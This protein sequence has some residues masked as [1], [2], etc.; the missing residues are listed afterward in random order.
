MNPYNP[1]MVPSQENPDQLVPFVKNKAKLDPVLSALLIARLHTQ[2]LSLTHSLSLFMS[3]YTQGFLKRQE[4]SHTGEKPFKC[5]M[6]G[7]SFSESGY[8]KR[9]L[10]GTK[11]ER[12][13]FSAP[14][15]TGF[16]HHQSSKFIRG[17]KGERL[18][19]RFIENTG[20]NTQEG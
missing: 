8:L 6:C 1:K 15:V 19:I 5:T 12:K 2:T 13:H 9:N 20:E 3:F 18:H 16:F 11:L 7:K 4:R 14:N 10:K 17:L